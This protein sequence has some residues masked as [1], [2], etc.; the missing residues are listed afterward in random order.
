MANNFSPY[1]QVNLDHE[2]KTTTLK[3]MEQPSQSCF[4]LAQSKIYTLMEK[5]CYP[6]FLK[7]TVYQ[8]LITQHLG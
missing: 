6:R 5:D 3:N 4:T 2:T 7:S 8:E 1:F